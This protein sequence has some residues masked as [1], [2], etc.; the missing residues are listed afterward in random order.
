MAVRKPTKK[1]APPVKIGGYLVTR[2]YGEPKHVRTFTEVISTVTDDLE[3]LLADAKRRGTENDRANIRTATTD[4]RRWT[5]SAHTLELV[6]DEHT[7]TRYS[8]LV[9][10]FS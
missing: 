9:E 10:V 7:N 4:V 5:P 3:A 2:K 1:K 8:V 6:V